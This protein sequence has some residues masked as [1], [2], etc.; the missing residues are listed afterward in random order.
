[1]VSS[2]RD[3]GFLTDTIPALTCW[4]K[5]VPALRASVRPGR[6]CDVE[7][8]SRPI[9]HVFLTTFPTRKRYHRGHEGTQRKATEEFSRQPTQHSSFLFLCSDDHPRPDGEI[10]RWPDDP[11]TR[12]SHVIFSRKSAPVISFGSGRPSMPRIVGEMSRREPPDFNLNCWAF[13]AMTMNGTGFVV[14]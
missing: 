1:M 13:S 9:Q 12:Y 4:A 11:I 8:A 2:L 5:F 14:W 6:G 7:R 3:S 10:T